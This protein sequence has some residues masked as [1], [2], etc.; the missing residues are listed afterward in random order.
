[1]LLP[2]DHHWGTWAAASPSALVHLPSGLGLR[3]STYSA[4][5]QR[6]EAHTGAASVTYLEH[7][8]TIRFRLAHSGSVV[9]V[10]ARR[11]GTDGLAIMSRLVEAGEWALRFWVHLEVGRIAPP[12]APC[13]IPSPLDATRVTIARRS[14]GVGAEDTV[15]ASWRS[16]HL[17]V[18]SDPP[19]ARAGRYARAE[20]LAEELERGGYYLPHDDAGD[21]RSTLGILRFSSQEQGTIRVGVAIANDAAAAV[22]RA[23]AVL[24]ALDTG[25]IAVLPVG[26]GGDATTDGHGAPARDAIREVVAWNTVWDHSN[27]R[28]MT[29]LTREWL[30][31]KFG[32]Y[33]IW[34]DDVAYAGFLAALGGDDAIARANLTTV[35]A[36]ETPQG[37][38]PCLLTSYEEW[39]D[40]S[41]PPVVAWMLLRTH[42]RRGDPA[43]V[44]ETLPAL[45]RNH[46][47]WWR[48]RD[49]LGEGLVA[50]GSSPTGRGTFRHTKQ[51][52]LNEASMDNLPLFDDAVFDRATST[53]DLH[54][55][56]LN[57]LLALDAELLARLARVVGE[58]EVAGHLEV[59]RGRH[60]E[61]VR[62]RLWNEEVGAFL[63]RRRDGSWNLHPTATT[64]LPLVAGIATPEQAAILVERHLLDEGAF[65]GP[66]P[67]PASSHA[68]PASSDRVYWRGRIWGPHVWMVWEG[69]VR[70][71]IDAVAEELAERAWRMFSD[72]WAERRC[73]ENLDPRGPDHDGGSDADPF[74]TWGALLAL[75]RALERADAN[76]W[77]GTFLD[78]RDGDVAVTVAD[79]RFALAGVG[80]GVVELSYSAIGSVPSALA[81]IR[82]ATRVEGLTGAGVE[83]AL[84]APARSEFVVE[85]VVSCIAARIDDGAWAAVPTGGMVVPA[86]ARLTLLRA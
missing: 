25:P 37:N 47:W 49:P 46:A 8:P 38:L 52:A 4:R 42:L 63:G 50:H 53:I 20:E 81:R 84:R 77:R 69:L 23:A 39:V 21:E 2:A 24:A 54:D 22:E 16:V 78:A 9:E 7:G 79:G 66:R 41:Q 36:G 71:G 44:R 68:D 55:P 10:T 5:E 74:Y 72:G 51:G 73:Y 12:T 76:P 19:A 61:R 27:G 29:A 59:E 58:E 80:D 45:L 31:G 70:L 64:F 17:A 48:A 32:G 26:S 13:P 34:L 43:L 35:V 67:L 33:G 75:P 56:G 40:R 1:M 57:A 28:P 86:G 60:A 11:E 65:W 83:V 3:V 30:G 62:D 15:E 6:Y 18:V 14:G 82:G 85:P